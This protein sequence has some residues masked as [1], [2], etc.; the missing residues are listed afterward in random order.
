MISM[1]TKA[2]LQAMADAMSD[3]PDD[4]MVG[5]FW[6]RIPACEYAQVPVLTPKQWLEF[7]RWWSEESPGLSSDLIFCLERFQATEDPA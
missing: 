6:D 2:Q 3:D 7:A 5:D 4:V 1:F